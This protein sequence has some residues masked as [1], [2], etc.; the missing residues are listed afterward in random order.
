MEITPAGCLCAECPLGPPARPVYGAGVADNVMV[1][2]E[3]PGATEVAQGEPFIG[4]SGRLLR[5]V[6]RDA[7][8]DPDT[9]VYYTNAVL[10]R[11]KAGVEL[12]RQAIAACNGRLREEIAMVRPRKVLAVG[13]PGLTAALS[14]PKL[15]R[16]T[17]ERGRARWLAYDG[18]R[19]VLMPSWHPAAV[20][21]S[22]ELIRD[23][24]RDVERLATIDKPEVEPEVEIVVVESEDEALAWLRE[25]WTASCLS[26]DLETE[27]LDPS[28]HRVN[29]I[30]FGALTEDGCGAVSVIIPRHFFSDRVLIAVA[31]LVENHDGPIIDFWNA[32]F[33][34]GML[35]TFFTKPLRPTGFRDGM[36]ESFAI[37]ERPMGSQSGRARGPGIHSL[38]TQART[39]YDDPGYALDI[40]KWL[41]TPEE[42]RDY[43]ALYK[44]Q[45]LDCYFTRRLADDLMHEL[46]HGDVD[47]ELLDGLLY[48][49]VLALKE[50]E[51]HGAL[52]D[53][54]RLVA[55]G[56][57]LTVQSAAI[58]ERV[59]EAARTPDLNLNSPLQLSRLLYGELGLR[60]PFRKHQKSKT[61]TDEA[62]LVTL[63]R[64]AT[65]VQKTVL[66]GILNF[67][68]INIALK[69]FVN[70]LLRRVSPDGRIR[71]NF[72]LHGTITGRLSSQGPNLQNIPKPDDENPDSLGHRI[73]RCFIAPP[74]WVIVEAD[75]SQL[76]LRVAAA[77][78]GDRVLR[79]NFVQGGDIHRQVAATIFRKPYDKV[80]KLERYVCKRINFGVIYGQTAKGLMEG[81][82][83]AKYGSGWTIRQA[84]EFIDHHRASFPELAQWVDDTIRHAHAYGVVETPFG[85]RR[86]FAYIP[87]RMKGET[88]RQ[89]VNA[90]IQATASDLCLDALI[91]LHDRLDP[92]QAAI[93]LTVHDSIALEVREDALLGVIALLHEVMEA[94][95]LETD[96]P[97]VVDIK[98]GPTWADVA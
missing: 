57:D 21:R 92:E 49:A 45:G 84:E 13:S 32:K 14:E 94:V 18:T 67:R 8:I 58:V 11:P 3:S 54:P 81:Q 64:T 73:R 2:G 52:L 50:I 72:L 87:E 17:K 59:R 55:L 24:R 7:G 38:K 63:L 82:D 15:T 86:R 53:I 78:S 5:T 66:Q 34:L 98:S 89:A 22:P 33:D 1:I 41:A 91:R 9:E 25:L 70:G 95:P 23:L 47:T 80:S 44:Y 56:V 43:D 97:F 76:E 4:E 6:L 96:V 74:G 31:D 93:I 28:Q 42:D 48:P 90:P 30:G 62:I 68:G 83:M 69:T 26:C 88:G 46:T 51:A 37:D 12:T 77:L 10:C 75:Y 35:D 16:I 60:R 27:G 71:S 19:A 65:A 85:R 29:S 40:K 39:R 61:H 79:E 20:L 36:L